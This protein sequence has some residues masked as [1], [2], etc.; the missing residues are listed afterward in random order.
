MGPKLF[1]QKSLRR[2]RWEA[3][4]AYRK[5]PAPRLA[6]AVSLFR[7]EVG[8]LR[9]TGWSQSERIGLPA[10]SD[11]LPIPWYTFP[12]I[13]FLEPR[14]PLHGAVFEFGMGNSTLWWSRRAASVDAV[15]HDAAWFAQI[16][17]TMPPN[18]TARLAEL[19]GPDYVNAAAASGK[20][21]SILVLDG[22][23]RVRCMKGSLAALAPEGVVIWDNSERD[24]Y[25]EGYE[26]LAENGFRR[27]D[28]WGLGPLS[29]HQWCTS[30]FYRPGNCLNI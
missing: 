17:A 11:G 8:Y 6:R 26:L 1:V 30:I 29:H 13:A 2:V 27:L 22:R 19:D 16:A 9:Q 23:R 28:F 10:D 12:A 18:V 7:N 3:T 21:Y 20:L 4:K 24:W 14:L 25:R 15:E 5:T